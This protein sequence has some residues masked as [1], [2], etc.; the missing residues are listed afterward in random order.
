MPHFINWRLEQAKVGVWWKAVSNEARVRSY[1]WSA[2]R[3][4]VSPSLAREAIPTPLPEEFQGL[5]LT[6]SCREWR[7]GELCKGQNTLAQLP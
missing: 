6:E 2:I 1:T 5:Y 7:W 4:Q 3:D